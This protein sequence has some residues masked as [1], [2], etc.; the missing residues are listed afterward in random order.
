MA[1]REFR[2]IISLSVMS[3]TSPASEANL[4]LEKKEAKE[5]TPK[6]NVMKE[7]FRPIQTIEEAQVARAVEE[8]R[9]RLQTTPNTR[10]YPPIGGGE[11]F[12]GSKKEFASIK[13]QGLRNYLEYIEVLH[14]QAPEMITVDVL[15]E[16]A[17]AIRTAVRENKI[18][19]AE[20]ARITK[21]ISERLAP[22]EPG[23]KTEREKKVR[24]GKMFSLKWT[25]LHKIPDEI[26]LPS[27]LRTGISRTISPSYTLSEIMDSGFSPLLEREAVAIIESSQEDG[28]ASAAI[29][30]MFPLMTLDETMATGSFGDIADKFKAVLP[31]GVG[32]WLSIDQETRRCLTLFLK[33]QGYKV[34]DEPGIQGSIPNLRAEGRVSRKFSELV[35]RRETKEGDRDTEKAEIAKELEVYLK[36]VQEN[37]GTDPGVVRLAFTIFRYFAFPVGI[38]PVQDLYT[39]YLYD[40]STGEGDLELKDVEPLL[41]RIKDDRS[42]EKLNDIVA[43]RGVVGLAETLAN[44]GVPLGKFAMDWGDLKSLGD[45]M[46]EVG[47]IRKGEGSYGNLDPGQRFV[48]IQKLV[49]KDLGTLLAKRKISQEAYNRILT[50]TRISGQ[51]KQA[52]VNLVAEQ[53]G[54]VK[55][56]QGKAIKTYNFL[57]GFN[58]LAP[59]GWKKPG[60]RK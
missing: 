14:A 36:A 12:L 57:E 42:G 5:I 52:S 9:T 55:D 22:R 24:E 11:D 53:A 60:R 25:R 19:A 13:N 28:F 1:Q 23:L 35:P 48:A 56:L 38:S 31:D 21:R 50:P 15:K 59:F 58:I 4:L 49:E 8:A 34:A 54:F 2:C 3:E 6:E 40:P 47:N 29:K 44:R 41:N 18:P 16:A 26:F 32:R 46:R 37:V 30:G 20:A 17:S 45:L 51:P 39:R 10:E 43:S 27:D 7:T 33:L